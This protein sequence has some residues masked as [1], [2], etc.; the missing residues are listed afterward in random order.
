MEKSLF[1]LSRIRSRL[2]VHL[3]SIALASLGTG[4]VLAAVI[5]V[6]NAA[7]AAAAPAAAAT[8]AD[9]APAD[10]APA[11]AATDQVR[12]TPTSLI[13]TPGERKALLAQYCSACHNDKALTAGMSVEKLD[14]EN[15][16][17]D[18]ATW[19]KI[20][21]RIS[22]G[23]MPPKGMRRPPHAQATAISGWLEASLD[24]LSAKNPDPGRATLRRLNRVEYANAV[25]DL[26]GYTVDVSNQLPADDSGYGFDNIA[27]VLTV[28]PTLIDRYMAV[29]ARV[30]TAATGT[31]SKRV[32]T[33]EF[34]TPKDVSF[35]GR[36]IPAYNERS[37]DNL[38]ISSRGGG[39]FE[40]YA[41][42]DGEYVIRLTLNPNTNGEQELLREASY[43][44]RVPLK[45][46]ART[47]GASFQR[48]FKLE[49]KVQALYSG[50]GG[51]G[52]VLPEG[53]PEPLSLRVQVDGVRVQ[54]VTVPSYNEG[55]NFYSARFPRDVLRISVIG[56]YSPANPGETA[57]RRKIFTCT[58][59][60]G[61]A[62]ERA[63]AQKILG[64]L[65]SEAYRRPVK[66]AELASLMKVYD[67]G[68]TSG[69]FEQGVEAGI[70]GI[71]VSPNFLFM[72]EEPPARTKPG[73]IYKI[74]DSELA[75]RLSLFLWSS[76]PDAELRTLAESGK[77]RKPGVLEG[78]IARMLADPK[79]RA[80]TR[81]FAG[82]WL[83][84]RNLDAQRPDIVAYPNFDMRLRQA[85]RTETELFFDSVVDENRSI[86]D[87]IRADYTYLNERLAE[88]Y[89]IPNVRGPAF[90]RVKLDPA[91]NRGGLLGQASI[92][93]VTSYDNRTSI[94][95]RGKWIL[96]NL[97]AAPPPPPPPNVPDLKEPEHG[98]KMTV[99]QQM[100][101]H[102]ASP[103]CASCHNKMDPLGLALENYDAVGKWRVKDSDLPVDPSAVLPDGTQ[104]SGPRGLQDILL[105]RKDQFAEAF[106]ER[107]LT[108][109][110][111]RGLEAP[112]MP[113][114]RKIRREAAADNY[115]IGTIIVGI[116]ESLPF[117]NRR[118]EAQ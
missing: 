54:E 30:A 86:L 111:S 99:R 38:P 87:F 84:L 75:T 106:I 33:T 108:Y 51:R 72:K 32:G 68:R 117:Q 69:G 94:V 109:G 21:R 107:L 34:R 93:T 49:E 55:P 43:D 80:L 73:Q 62:S 81:N 4:S 46:G 105:T 36:G 2:R 96:D 53:R 40:Y 22:L 25:R 31:A 16:G 67:D 52:V 95:R 85:M 102:R 41:P 78:Q 82:Q 77:L 98:K 11:S 13:N 42:Y 26:L 44:V 66:K 28:S 5:A 115:K 48:S 104:F 92:L 27:D 6:N 113:A 89:E 71:L 47:I 29:A 103:V 64:R 19:E 10:P 50:P 18:V 15:I 116:V 114:V 65:A 7:S 91:S 74:S 56:P 100:E 101:L 8:P 63:C 3:G 59:Q 45:A 97:L 112:D 14:V 118:M 79:A 24:D 61:A 60:P 35:S 9:A 12:L 20:L 23:E 88:H 17:R 110:L 1:A 83:Y 37:S 58:P 39:S 90:R 70:E 57:S 76:I